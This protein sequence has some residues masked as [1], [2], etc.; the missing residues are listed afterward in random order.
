MAKLLQKLGI[1]SETAENGA[2]GVRR[3]QEADMRECC[4]GYRLILMDLN[5]PIMDGIQATR[6]IFHEHEEGHISRQPTV[7]ACTAFASEQERNLCTEVGMASVVPKPVSL[8]SIREAITP[9][10]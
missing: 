5:M 1:V 7:L 6:S 3:V 2:E 8:D 9:Y 4:G 10:I